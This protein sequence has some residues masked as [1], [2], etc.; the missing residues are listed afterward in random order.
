MLP[1]LAVVADCCLARK[2]LANLEEVTIS[3][4]FLPS[5]TIVSFVQASASLVVFPPLFPA[6]IDH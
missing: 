1:T 4:L 2:V 5:L 6:A 3:A